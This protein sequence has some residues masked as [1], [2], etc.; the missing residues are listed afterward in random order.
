MVSPFVRR[1][2]LATV[3][4]E[5]REERGMMADELAKRIH[6]SRTKISRLENAYG[7]PD[8]GDVIKILDAFGITGT[9]WEEIVRLADDASTKGWWDRYGD[10][11]GTRQRLYADI[12]SGAATIREYN[13]TTVPGL[14]QTLE[15][16]SALVKP[17]RAEGALGFS[18][19]KMIEAR[20]RRQKLILSPDGPSYD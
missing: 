5:L 1:Q 11:M 10:A 16:S 7:R 3:L 18:P 8:V 9:K 2:R 4:R 6:Y 17:K 12:E 13:N 19:S 20:E 15:F 14:L